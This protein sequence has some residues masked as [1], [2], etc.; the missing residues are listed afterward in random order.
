MCKLFEISRTGLYY[1]PAGEDEYDLLLKRLIDEE[2]TKFP[3]YGSRKMREYLIRQGHIVGREKVQ[4]L[5]REMGIEGIYPHK[6][7]SK[8]NKEHAV[9]P[10]LLR[11]VKIT[12]PNQVWCADITYIR[13][14]HGF[15]YLTAIMDWYSRYV[16]SWRLSNTLDAGFCI[17][18]LKDAFKTGIAE[19]FNSDQGAQFTSISFT[20][21]LKA[22]KI[23][24]SMDGKGRAMDNIF[25]ERLWRTLKYEDIYINNYETV[26][27]LEAGLIRY[28]KLYNNERLHQA[29]G[30]K[31][32]WEVYFGIGNMPNG[33]EIVH[34]GANKEVILAEKQIITA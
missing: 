2:Y 21:V 23:L 32:P 8:P 9:Y 28:F 30:Y 16:L 29:L 24:I 6:N 11:D 14:R 10:Y 33:T 12:H 31:T 20:D 18:V 7:T 19:T 1:K 25:I 15:M 17:D 26:R 5:M 13:L 4:R 27:E 22:N 3:V 34:P